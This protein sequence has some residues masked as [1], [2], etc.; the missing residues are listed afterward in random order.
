MHSKN[1]TFLVFFFLC[2]H[3]RRATV[4]Q[5]SE[6]LRRGVTAERFKVMDHVHLVVVAEIVGYIQPRSRRTCNLGIKR[7]LETR[8]ACEGFWRNAHLTEEDAFKLS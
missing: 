8:N 6:Q 3:R 1:A 2:N 5:P 7:R 4:T